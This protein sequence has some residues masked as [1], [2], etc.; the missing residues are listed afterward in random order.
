MQLKGKGELDAP[1]LAAELIHRRA[2]LLE[3]TQT[4]ERLR[5]RVEGFE[6]RYGIPSAEVHAAIEAGRLRET[7]E[8]CDWI[9]DDEL[10]RAAE[11]E[12]AR[13]APRLE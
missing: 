9:L 8:V 7:D 6:R 3:H 13:R 1:T 2:I 5:A 10:V 11:A 12:P 4:L